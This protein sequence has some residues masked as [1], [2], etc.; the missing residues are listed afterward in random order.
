MNRWNY[1]GETEESRDLEFMKISVRKETSEL[2]YLLYTPVN[3]EFKVFSPIIQIVSMEIPNSKV[4]IDNKKIE[5]IV[6]D[7]ALDAVSQMSKTGII[8]NPNTQEN[9]KTILTSLGIHE[10]EFSVI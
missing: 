7:L 10:F 2:S 3:P 5:N 8:F 6:N 9:A 1:I 4:S